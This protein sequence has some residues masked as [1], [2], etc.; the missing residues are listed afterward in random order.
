[1]KTS[2]PFLCVAF[3]SMTAN[4]FLTVSPKSCP[5]DKIWDEKRQICKNCV[6]GYFGVN[7]SRTCRFPS[8]GDDCQQQC[9]CTPKYCHPSKGC[10]FTYEKDLDNRVTHTYV[11]NILLGIIVLLLTLLVVFQALTFRLRILCRRP[12][13]QRDSKSVS[14]RYHRYEVPQPI[15]DDSMSYLD[16]VRLTDSETDRNNEVITS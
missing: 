8:F 5:P 9:Y 15:P 1:M 11:S 14:I 3:S 7:C 12:I 2:V 10:I 4:S 6:S 16:A 13:R